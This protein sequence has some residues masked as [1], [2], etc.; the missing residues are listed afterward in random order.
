MW[1]AVRINLEVDGPCPF[2]ATRREHGR[3]TF[4]P[5]CDVVGEVGVDDRAVGSEQPPVVDDAVVDARPRD[6]RVLLGG[7][8]VD[9]TCAVGG[10]PDVWPSGSVQEPPPGSPCDAFVVRHED[11]R[12]ETSRANEGVEAAIT[13]RI[14][15]G[16][17]HR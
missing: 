2:P 3:E 15:V 11:V 8:D 6:V 13:G 4:R 9:P 7:E 17:H 1:P 10:I 16:V 12:V 5:D 14:H